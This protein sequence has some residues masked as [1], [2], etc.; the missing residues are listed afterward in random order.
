[1]TFDHV[2]SWFASLKIND[3]LSILSAVVAAFSFLLSRATVRRQEAMQVEAFRTNVITRLSPGPMLR[4][5]AS[6]MLSAT[7]VTSRTV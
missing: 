5:Q 6:P 3:L 4:S 2:F 1:V 7:A